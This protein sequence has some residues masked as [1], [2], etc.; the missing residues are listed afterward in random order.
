MAFNPAPT[1]LFASWSEDATNITVPIAS[2]PELTAAEADASDGDSRK[3][4]YALME[5]LYAW[6]NALDTAD[7]PAKMIVRRSMSVE[8]PSVS[9]VVYTV[10]F[11][12]ATASE[13]AAE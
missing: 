9:R 6:Y 10:T 13:V 5:Q 4:A 12:L 1:A 7:K 8:S 3:I 11:D 2:I